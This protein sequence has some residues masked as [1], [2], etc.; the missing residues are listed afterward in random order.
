MAIGTKG[1]VLAC[2]LL[3]A[4]C[5]GGAEQR[6]NARGGGTTA[7]APG[8]NGDPESSGRALYQRACVMCHG[9]RGAGTQLGPALNDSARTVDAIAQVVTSGVPQAEPPHTPMP[10]RGDG[11]FSEQDVRA[12]AEYVRSLAR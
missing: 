8:A 12:V 2:A 3:L 9:E 4:A 5:G 6:G 11:T 1:A 7:S 10:P